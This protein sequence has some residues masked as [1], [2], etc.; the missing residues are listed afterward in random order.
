MY[1]LFLFLFFFG[2]QNRYG[3]GSL[4]SSRKYYFWKI[5]VILILILLFYY[6]ASTTSLCKSII[7]AMIRCHP[8]HSN[9]DDF[10]LRDHMCWSTSIYREVGL[11]LTQNII[12]II[13]K[14]IKEKAL[15]KFTIIV[16][17]LCQMGLT[18]VKVSW[19]AQWFFL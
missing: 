6:N 12:I 19:V 15:S 17:P 13:E 1:I 4:K 3:P 9:S 14:K 2:F 8:D 11:G 7:I 10:V 18:E 16:I 5:I